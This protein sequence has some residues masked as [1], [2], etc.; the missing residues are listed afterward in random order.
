[1][2]IF[3]RGIYVKYTWHVAERILAITQISLWKY[4]R[5]DRSAAHWRYASVH[6]NSKSSRGRR[7]QTSQPRCVLWRHPP[8]PLDRLVYSYNILPN[9][10]NED[11]GCWLECRWALYSQKNRLWPSEEREQ[12]ANSDRR[13]SRGGDVT[14][15]DKTD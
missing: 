11:A 14:V 15:S 13:L 6:D 3:A 9:F 4:R 5:E 10:Q 8:D 1:M 2:D 12:G 7:L